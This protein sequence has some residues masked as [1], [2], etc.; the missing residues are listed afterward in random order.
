MKKKKSWREEYREYGCL[1]GG[2]GNITYE[3]DGKMK[4]KKIKFVGKFW[5]IEELDRTENDPYFKGVVF[6]MF[7]NEQGSVTWTKKEFYENCKT[8][9]EL[10]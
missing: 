6:D 5:H 8:F 9:T 10:F 3:L 7:N 4:T 1:I 2:L